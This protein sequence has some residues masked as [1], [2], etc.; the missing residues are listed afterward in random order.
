MR[1]PL[2][3]SVCTT[4]V[5]LAGCAD[6]GDDVSADLITP[7]VW[8]VRGD[9]DHILAWVHNGGD[10]QASVDWS[11][12]S[13]NGEPLPAGWTVTF[14]TPS[15]T[16]SPDG[17]KVQGARGMTY[18]DWART[19]LT[20]EL[21]QNAPAGEFALELHAGDATRDIAATVHA[22]RVDV[23]GPGSKVT[24]QYEGRFADTGDL[25]DD[26]EFPTV[27]G[28]GGTVAGFDYGLMGLAAGETATIVIPPAFG[29]GYDP[30]RSHAKFAGETLEFKV[31]L[32]E[33]EG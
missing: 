26:G 24:V 4:F 8:D 20:L 12:T 6:K 30:P 11:L 7:G 29:Y 23:S 2:I 19:L 25:F 9:T 22:N 32:T 16:L 17:T 1:G 28:S 21:P 18:P 3:A 15:A 5:L 33:L 14:S 27:L 10:E 13:A 31:T